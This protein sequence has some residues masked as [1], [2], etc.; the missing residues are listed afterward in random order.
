[1]YTF[2]MTRRQQ[3]AVGGAIFNSKNEVLFVRRAANDDFMPS[4]WEIPGGGTEY[5]EKPT[6]GLKR[7]IMEE[8]G[9]EITVGRPVCVCDY[10]VQNNAESVHR[11]EIVFLCKLVSDSANVKL[12][13]E[14]DLC[15]W[16][17]LGK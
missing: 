13:D 2:Q 6:D 7:E 17:N 15:L 12:S 10:Y 14:H 4:V 16:M 3:V 1:R 5:G 8:C 11:V 9:I